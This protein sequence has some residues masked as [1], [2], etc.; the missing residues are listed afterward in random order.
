MLSAPL[1]KKVALTIY[2]MGIFH[3]LHQAVKEAWECEGDTDV[4]PKMGEYALSLAHQ[5][6]DQDCVNEFSSRSTFLA[7]LKFE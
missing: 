1:E 5:D 7:C 6:V 3:S 2:S 4:T